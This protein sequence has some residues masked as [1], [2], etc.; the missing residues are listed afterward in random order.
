MA[1]KKTK[2]I[3]VSQED[4]AQAQRVLEQYQQIANNLH[5]S[6]DQKQAEAA[7]TEINNMS[8]GAQIA[9]LKALSKES[10]TDAA[11]VLVAINELSPVKGVRKEARRSLIQLEGA[12]IYPE[13]SPPVDRTPVIQVASGPAHFWKGMVTD[14]LD[15]GE[16]QLLLLFEQEDDPKEIRVLGFLLDFVYDGVKD[17]FTRIESKRSVDNFIAQMSASMPDVKTK[18]CSLA[19]GR[20]LLLDALA[21][22]KRHGTVPYKDYR[23]NLS[24]VNQLVLEAP[25]LGEDSEDSIDEDIESVDED[26]EDGPD[27]HDLSPQDVVVNFVESWVDGD[28]DLAYDLL[29]SDSL[30]REGLSRDEWIERRDDWADEANPGDL[31]PNFLHE[32]EPQKSLLWLPNPFSASRS[33]THKEVEAG[34]SIE[35]DETSLSETLPELP[36]ATAVYE[37]TGRH[38]F[39]TN[40]TLVQDQGEWRIQSMTD[41][42]KNAIGLPVEELQKRIKEHNKYLEEFVQ[43]HAPTDADAQQQLET[44]LWRLMQVVYYSDALI[45]KLPV[46]RSVYENAAARML[47][48]QQYERCI[49]YVEPLIQHFPEQRGVNLRRLA[50]IQIELSEKY[51]DEGDDERAERFQQLAEEALRES[52]AI[53]DS[54]EAHISMAELLIDMNERLNEAEDHLLQAKALATSPDEEAHVEM[55]LGEIAME[56]EQFE[57]A[58]SHYQRVAEIEPDSAKTWVD[59]A[60]AYKGLENFEEAEANYRHAIGSEPDD[61]DLYFKLS[62]MYSENNQPAKA[63]EAIEDGLS[64]NPDSAVLN[65]Y[66]ATVYLD[67]GDYRQAEIFLE[68]A[69][70]IDPESE[71]VLM[72]RQ[73]LNLNKSLQAVS[74][75]KQTPS[76]SR[77]KHKKKKR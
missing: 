68:R 76:I 45:K 20:R 44:I 6:T 19:Q 62:K 1:K 50:A 28:Y 70:R 21:V 10:H 60:E 49:V 77:P 64:V 23:Y 52:L 32:R 54:F 29:S 39:W 56:Q 69:E 16:V 13:W 12:R 47:V 2:Q 37:E 72:F 40:Y 35:L 48:F 7:L 9:L 65:V 4:S 46:D 27:L 58:L 53:E 31:E 42:G 63:I 75:P 22:N 14:S 59:I 15:V 51:F 57:Q 67:T 26:S 8:E 3:P 17:F 61:E 11:D 71:L 33:T 55:H 34:W 25:D 24:L 41:E 5:T 36:Q 74:R 43:K 38:W 30:L 18:D 66:L 73:V